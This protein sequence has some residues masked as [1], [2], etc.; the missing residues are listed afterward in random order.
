LSPNGKI[1][2][3]SLPAP[4]Y[5]HPD[6]AREYQAPRTPTEETIAAILAEVLKLDRVGVDDTFFDLGGHSLL[7]TQVISRIR[8]AFQL[9][10]PLRTIFE[11]PTVAGLAESLTRLQRDPLCLQAPPIKPMPRTDRLPLSFAQQRLWFLDQLE[12]N[13]SLYNIPRAL[14]LKG[15]LRVSALEAAL[16]SIVERHEVLHTTYAFDKGQPHQVIAEEVKQPL[17]VIDLRTLS[18]SEREKEARRIVQEKAAIP[19]DLARDPMIRYLII[20]MADD[21]H[22]LVVVTHHIADDGWSTGVLWRDLAELYEA[23]LLGKAP[24]LPPL[25][26]QY[27]DYAVWQR[28]WMQG[29]VL[30]Q[31]VSYWRERLAGAPPVLVLPTD[32][33]RPGKPTYRGAVHRFRL[34]A[35]LLEAVQ[36][37]SRQHGC[38]AFMTLLAG[39]KSLL[40]YYAG[41][42]DIVLGTDLANRTTVQT[43]SLI[44][45]FVN[46]VA[47]RTDLS[48]DP[49]FEELLGRV[50]ETALG[51]YA[52]Q[53]VPFDKLVE[54]L[55]PERS[56]S[57]NPIVQML[58]VQQN[59]P[60]SSKP[61]PGLLS[62]SYPIEP[63]SK[64]D[65]AVFVMETDQGLVGN[66]VYSTELFEATTIARMAELYQVV[67]EQATAKPSIRLTELLAAIADEDLQH[68]VTQHKQLQEKG[69]QRLK[70]AKRKSLM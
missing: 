39:F 2:R 59:T 9:E 68:R 15:V 51:A 22:I 58:F 10:V 65:F 33:S 17:R 47:L 32:S 24:P 63:P 30:R 36:S 8:Q 21:D 54:Q 23:T 70:T 53:D 4:G 67:I 41:Q 16:N 61:L 64:F 57:H 31:Q 38:T 25:E 62:E 14:R 44:G 1:D 46:L 7:A 55:Q 18:S 48:G 52:H 28:Q 56:L 34:S 43:E 29:E 11:A 27:A 26:I 37:L 19:F 50:R 5:E 3:K 35:M 20:E 49:T 42:T 13:T 66:W 60:R 6:L 12:P 69:S 40:L 45:F